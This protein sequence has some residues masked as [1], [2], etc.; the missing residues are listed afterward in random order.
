M[1]IVLSIAGLSSNARWSYVR[2][3]RDEWRRTTICP[4]PEKPAVKNLKKPGKRQ[5]RQLRVA[6]D[7]NVLYT[8]SASDLVRQ[9]AGNMVTQSAYPDLEV[10]WYLPEV[11]RHERQYQMR[12][13]ALELL[14]SVAKVERLLGHNLNIT[15]EILVDRV[16]K[17]VTACQ[18]EM[19][20]LPIKL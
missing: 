20:L 6:F 13:R 16:E 1:R 4:P 10:L 17:A 2:H 14:P 11:V 3:T 19:G 9:E 8:G 5:K 7:T 12:K 18:N 15:Q